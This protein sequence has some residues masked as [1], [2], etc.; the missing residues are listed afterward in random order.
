MASAPPPPTATTTAGSGGTPVAA[1]PIAGVPR[2]H[3][4][5][6]EALLLPEP[7]ER[8]VNISNSPHEGTVDEICG[9]V[10]KLAGA[11]SGVYACGTL[12]YCVTEIPA[13]TAGEPYGTL[14]IAT[15]GAGGGQSSIAEADSASAP[16]FEPGLASYELLPINVDSRGT[17]VC[18]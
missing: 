13:E 5:G 2:G 8:F 6:G 15:A 11:P 7:V 12:L 14:E 9:G 10:P 3:D 17:V 1:A 16:E 4:L 18:G